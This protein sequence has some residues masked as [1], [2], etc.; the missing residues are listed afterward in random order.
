MGES[1]SEEKYGVHGK[2]RKAQ[3]FKL[4][5]LLI[6]RIFSKLPVFLVKAVI[7]MWPNSVQDFPVSSYYWVSDSLRL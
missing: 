6:Y 5:L 7:N 1:V 2:I 3:D 4:S